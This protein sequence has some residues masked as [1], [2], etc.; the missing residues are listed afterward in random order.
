MTFALFALLTSAPE[1]DCR[2]NNARRFTF[3]PTRDTKFIFKNMP[4]P[5]DS[6]PHAHLFMSREHMFMIRRHLFMTHEHMFMPCTLKRMRHVIHSKPY[7]I[8]RKLA[9]MRKHAIVAEK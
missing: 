7:T 2:V 9:E 4:H 8:K 5:I 3:I 6:K 1:R